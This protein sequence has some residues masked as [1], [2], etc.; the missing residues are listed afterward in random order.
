[1]RFRTI[2]L[3]LGLAG[4]PS[5]ALTAPAQYAVT[6]LEDAGGQGYN[7][8]S[9][10]AINGSG[11]SVGLS[12]A[13]TN[14]QF[15]DAALWSPTGKAT[16]L[17]DPG[18]RGISHVYAI[19]DSGQSVGSFATTNGGLDPV[20][21]SPSGK[22]TLLQ[23]PGGFG[24]V[25]AGNASGESAGYSG[26]H[27]ALWSS[28][29][30]APVLEAPG[31]GRSQ[32]V[33]INSSGWSVECSLGPPGIEEAVL[34]SPSGKATV[35]QDAGGGNDS[36]VYAVNDAGWSVGVSPTTRF[37]LED[38]VLW[39]RTGKATVLQDAGGRGI[40]AAYA[41]NDARWSVGF[42]GTAN[43]VEEAVLWSPWGKATNLG[44]VLGP[45][46]SHTDAVGINNSGGIV[47]FAFRYK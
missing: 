35:L 18:G 19:N 32:A 17:Q 29:G 4:T 31:A 39:S 9:L 34:W 40:D 27:A 10:N 7:F 15:A 28:S 6:V 22:V 5:L 12:Y 42:S 38:A 45:A 26:Q 33:A 14:G 23:D 8:P 2:A 47:H 41:I 13:T 37:G 24:E 11:Q 3:C 1:M 46:W 25:L 16:V 43:G 44:A 21:W 20:R 36:Y 30:K